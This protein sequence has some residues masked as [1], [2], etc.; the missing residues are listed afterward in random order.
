VNEKADNLDYYSQPLVMFIDWLVDMG[1]KDITAHDL[2]I[3]ALG[4]L[5]ETAFDELVRVSGKAE[6]LAAVKPYRKQTMQYPIVGIRNQMKLESNGVDTLL[7]IYL[8]AATFGIDPENMKG[9]IKEKGGVGTLQD[10]IFKDGSPEH[11]MSISHFCSE[12]LTE[13]VN[14]E[15]EALW[16][17]H[18]SNGDPF[19]R[20]VFKMKTDPISVLDDMG[21]TLG[22][23]PKFE[24]DKHQI[25]GQSIFSLA[26]MLNNDTSAFIDLHGSPKTIETL[27]ANAYRV[28]QEIGKELVGVGGSIKP[29]ARSLSELIGPL[30]RTFRQRATIDINSDDEVSSEIMDCNLQR[31]CPYEECRQLESLFKGIV[32]AINP[33]YEF[34]YDRMKSKG[35][36]NC[37]WVI[38]RKHQPS[39]VEGIEP[40]STKDPARALALRFGKG[41]ISHEEFENSIAALRKH[42]AIK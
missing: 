11:C 9:E 15:Y 24:L 40:E 19:C 34:F 33:D 1:G 23:L 38:R 22:T 13:F 29:N 36:E 7:L 14:P 16:T 6:A 27:G 41:E 5:N 37:H 25:Q 12:F 21:S 35:D 18:Q 10:C 28:G 30:E 39:K 26:Y 8:M 4:K 17:Q 32:N 2:M 20:V 42:G 31:N 3:K